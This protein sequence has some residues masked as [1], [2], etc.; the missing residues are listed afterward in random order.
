V[1]S[2][3]HC[4]TGRWSSP[5]KVASYRWYRGTRRI[6]RAAAATY[7]VR[8]IDAGARLHCEIVSAGTPAHPTS[9]ASASHAV[10]RTRP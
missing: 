3:L 8:T 6:A 2:I 5:P 1:G 7:R 9:K 10:V 4:G